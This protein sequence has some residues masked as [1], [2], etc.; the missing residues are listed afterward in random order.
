MK[1]ARLMLPVAIATS[2]FIGFSGSVFAASKIAQPH[3]DLGMDVATAP[4]LN[5]PNM[6]LDAAKPVGVKVAGRRGRRAVGAIIALGAA[7][8]IANE[9]SRSNRRRYNRYSRPKF[10]AYNNNYAYNS[11]RHRRAERFRRCDRWLR[12]CD[13]GIR[14][15]CRNFNRRCDF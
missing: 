3:S 7:A 2:L 6:T 10:R 8:V 4:E 12:R 15:A 9:I 14:R 13:R 1:F 11:R 5:V